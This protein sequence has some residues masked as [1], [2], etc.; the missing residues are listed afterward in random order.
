MLTSAW[1]SE[2]S[3]LSQKAAVTEMPVLSVRDSFYVIATPQEQKYN[4]PPANII[5]LQEF[6]KVCRFHRALQMRTPFA[7]AAARAGEATLWKGWGGTW[8]GAALWVPPPAD[9]RLTAVLGSGCISGSFLC[10]LGKTSDPA[11]HCRRGEAGGANA[12]QMFAPVASSLLMMVERPSPPPELTQT[13]LLSKLLPHQAS[14]PLLWGSAPSGRVPRAKPGSLSA[15]PALAGNPD[16]S[17][18][19]AKSMSPFCQTR[20]CKAAGALLK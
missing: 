16:P 2:K 6:L 13:P 1:A 18:A 7:E 5:S 19:L 20:T 15:S 14:P 11:P 12:Q 4:L 3:R 8:H 17:R 10:G 9:A